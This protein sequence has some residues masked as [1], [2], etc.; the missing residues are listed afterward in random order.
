ML[1]LNY[2]FSK[3]LLTV[4]RLGSLRERRYI[5]VHYYYYYYY[6]SS[7]PRH[8]NYG[9]PPSPPGELTLLIAPH[10]SILPPQ[11]EL[12]NAR[13][14]KCRGEDSRMFKKTRE[15]WKEIA[16]MTCYYV[17][18]PEEIIQV[19]NWLHSDYSKLIVFVIVFFVDGDWYMF[20][21]FSWLVSVSFSK[22][23]NNL[24]LRSKLNS[25]ANACYAGYNN[26]FIL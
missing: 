9:V 16:F 21:F 25:R 22:L 20:T 3:Y 24:S 19:N 1:H 23:A 8:F 12:K 2:L 7:H 10:W 26:F 18:S 11:Q 4:K 6:Y 13:C 14:Q 5:S 17:S 15:K